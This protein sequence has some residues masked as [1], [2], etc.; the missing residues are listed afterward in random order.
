MQNGMLNFLLFI[1]SFKALPKSTHLPLVV[2][3]N[4]WKEGNSCVCRVVELWGAM[5]RA[6]TGL[7]LEQ[8]PV[9]QTSCR[10][11]MNPGGT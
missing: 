6:R 2:Q 7:V 4:T 8:K 10:V 5:V 11:L 3:R 1:A 9:P